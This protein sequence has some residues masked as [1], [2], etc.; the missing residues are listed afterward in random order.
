MQKQHICQRM[1]RTG[2]NLSRPSPCPLFI[3]RRPQDTLHCPRLDLTGCPLS[4]HG[5][6][7]AP[8]LISFQNAT[9]ELGLSIIFRWRP[10][11]A[12]E[13]DVAAEG[14]SLSVPSKGGTGSPQPA[15]WSCLTRLLCKKRPC[16]QLTEPPLL[17]AHDVE[18][19]CPGALEGHRQRDTSG[20]QSQ[21]KAAP[22]LEPVPWVPPRYDQWQVTEAS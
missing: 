3:S 9:S 17:L 10:S 6:S 14:G 8:V 13:S 16:F 5:R 15:S 19:T 4:P 11:S 1:C 18:P 20:G 22:C 12:S 7:L 21:I 2:K